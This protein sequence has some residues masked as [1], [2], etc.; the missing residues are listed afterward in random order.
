MQMKEVRVKNFR[1]IR[2]ETLPCESLTALVGRNGAGKSAFLS[3]IELFYDNSARVAIEDFYSEDVT[4]DVEIAVTFSDIGS[5]AKK[6]FSS[7]IDNECLTVVKVFSYAEGKGSD[8]YHGMRLQ[9]RNFVSI[10]NAGGNMDIRR[11]YNEVRQRPEYAS[12]PT[13][14]SADAVRRELADWESENPD[15]CER[16]RDDGQFFGFK[17]VGQGF[18]G[19]HTKF[20]R[21]PA[22]RDAQDDATEGR[23]SS[24]TEIMDLVVR[25]ALAN[26]KDLV[27]F[28]QNTRNRYNEMMAPSNLTE[29][30][31]LQSS[32]SHTLQSYVSGSGVL[33]H[34]EEFS[35]ISFPDPK[36]QVK[37]MEDGFESTVER[38]GHGLQRAFIVTMLQHL[39]AARET[40]TTLDD[41]DPGREEDQAGDAQNLPCLVMAIE[42]PEL[43]Q[44]PSRQRHLSSV[45]LDLASGE[46][47][48][49]A[50][51]TQVIYTTHS[52]LLVGLDRFD[53]IRVLRK[54]SSDKSRPRVT[55]LKKVDIEAVAEELWKAD[56]EIGE[57]YTAT[58]LRPRLQTIMTPWMNEGFFA[59]TVVLVEGE[60]DRTA[61]LGVARSM[62][63]DFDQSGISVIPCFGKN[64][65]ARPFAIFRQLGI[66]VYV[67]WD[68][69][70]GRS[71]A[72]PEDN[73]SLLRI[74]QQSEEDWPEFV[75]ATC[76]SF[77]QDLEKSLENE[78]GQDLFNELLKEAQVTLGI[79]KKKQ[80]IKNV[81]VIQ[82]IVEKAAAQGQ[83][84]SSLEQ[85]VTNI[86][87]LNA[88]Q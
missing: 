60:D 17:Q 71:N 7:Y 78:I 67:V 31:D 11:K 72:K 39:V 15:Q 33:L 10:R 69:D 86:V 47:P 3:A 16:L 66:P 4:E 83:T 22:V 68:G 40:A 73:R 21:I 6:L 20:I 26:R 82:H 45:L 53:Q 41:T 12:L 28:K 43:Y 35:D 38:T 18:L 13:A 50:A 51:R 46:I 85:I 79:E 58:T 49:V 55:K 59:D 29:L 5:A 75:G 56:G 9:N 30:N 52:P 64:N 54:G 8:A 1:S 70:H 19:Q 76:A 44:H 87:A 25:S 27:D 65:L 61:I 37:L 32:L 74:L 57:K 36:A 77:K 81:S 23:G 84:C 80:A 88:Q 34:W 24:V 14:S 63:R 62:D 42:E 2:D 48:G